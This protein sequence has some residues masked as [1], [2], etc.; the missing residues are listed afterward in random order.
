MVTMCIVFVRYIY[1][2][3]FIF[4]TIDTDTSVSPTKPETCLRIE[5]KPSQYEPDRNK[6]RVNQLIRFIENYQLHIFWVSLYTLVLFG[7]FIEKA[8]CKLLFLYNTYFFS[9]IF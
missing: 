6:Q 4:S 8:Y 1:W 5:T 2:A 3:L 9:V 7:I